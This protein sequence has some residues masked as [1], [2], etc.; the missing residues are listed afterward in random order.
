MTE[1]VQSEDVKLAG[2]TGGPNPASGS[3][4]AARGL[5][6]HSKDADHSAGKPAERRNEG[7]TP[8]AGTERS[9]KTE[10]L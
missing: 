1:K 5:G 4:D 8:K 10:P 9:L 3:S 7:G 6:G 2:T